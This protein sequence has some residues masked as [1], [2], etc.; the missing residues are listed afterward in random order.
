ML[1]RTRTL[2]TSGDTSD[3]ASGVGTKYPAAARIRF[4]VTHTAARAHRRSPERYRGRPGRRKPARTGSDIVSCW[5]TFGGGAHLL[6]ES[7]KAL[8]SVLNPKDASRS[9]AVRIRSTA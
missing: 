4:G 1:S 6:R 7:A 2:P 5:H 9:A 3:D 8:P